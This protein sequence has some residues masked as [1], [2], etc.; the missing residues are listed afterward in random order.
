MSMRVSG[1]EESCLESSSTVEV[2]TSEDASPSQTTISAAPRCEPSPLLRIFSSKEVVPQILEY[3]KAVLVMKEHDYAKAPER[4]EVLKLS[5]LLAES[6]PLCEDSRQDP[7]PV[8]SMADLNTLLSTRKELALFRESLSKR[9]DSVLPNHC[10]EVIGMQIELIREQQ[11][12]LQDKDKELNTARKDKE[13][14]GI[15]CF[16]RREHVK[17]I[18]PR[19]EFPFRQ[20]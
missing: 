15:D 18:P 12:Q 2:R 6:P 8:D 16:P 10:R 14:V 9:E 1:G 20:L 5:S 7:E 13:Q 11:E 17:M 3:E 19:R 4:P